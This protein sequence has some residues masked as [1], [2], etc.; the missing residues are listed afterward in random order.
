MVEWVEVELGYLSRGLDRF[1]LWSIYSGYRLMIVEGHPS[2]VE[3][4]LLGRSFHHCIC[5][6]GFSSSSFEFFHHWHHLSPIRSTAN[7]WPSFTHSQNFQNST[8]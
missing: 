5:T 3:G 4:L 1:G 8:I 6:S 7:Y 2:R